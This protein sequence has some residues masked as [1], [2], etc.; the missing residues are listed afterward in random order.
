MIPRSPENH[1]HFIRTFSCHIAEVLPKLFSS[2]EFKGV[3]GFNGQS[4]KIINEMQ[5]RFE[6]HKPNKS[7][8]VLVNLGFLLHRE[9]FNG[10]I[11]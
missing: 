9:I 11:E 6:F 3:E 10:Y 7:R 4:V 8:Q 2:V 5:F 1:K